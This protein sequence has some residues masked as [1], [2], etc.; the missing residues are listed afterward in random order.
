[1][2][3]GT[4]IIHIPV[5]NEVVRNLTHDGLDILF[6]HLAEVQPSYVSILILLS[7]LII[8]L[9]SYCMTKLWRRRQH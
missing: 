7:M 4:V 5:G 8:I 3:N 1:M 2:S 6:K 9:L